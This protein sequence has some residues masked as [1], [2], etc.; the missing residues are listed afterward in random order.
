MT[1]TTSNLAAGADAT[2]SRSQAPA[3]TAF[4]NQ[5]L[6][7]DGELEPDQDSTYGSVGDGSETTSLHSSIVRGYIENGRRYQT[8]REGKEQYFVPADE[9]QYE[10]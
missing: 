9:K 4:P 6:P 7:E 2:A 1:G 8:V 3:A 5:P 10:R